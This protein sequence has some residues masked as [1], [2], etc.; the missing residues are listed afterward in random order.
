[1]AITTTVRDFLQGVSTTLMDSPQFSRWPEVELV[2]YINYGQRAIAKYLPHA[3]SRVDAIRLQNGTRQ[4]LTRVLAANIIP[5]DG[6]TAADTYGIAL[7]ELR[8]NMGANG[9]TAGRVIRIVDRYTA[10]TSDP[11]WH[12]R[13]G[14]SIK[15]YVFEKHTPKSFEVRPGV[16]GNVWA[17]VSWMAEPAFVAAGGAPGSEVYAA[18]GSSTVRLGIHDQYVEDLHNYVVGMALLKGSKNVQN[19]PKAQLHIGAFTSSI[20]AQSAVIS[21]V[22]PN[23]KQLPFFNEV[24]EAA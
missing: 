10:D 9:S 19:M 12:T 1:M 11:D 2:R 22:N 14:S 3:G 21:G 17:E 18:D 13:T 8:K 20:N 4:D 7:I 24:A 6:S 16:T 5:G 23:L 15:E